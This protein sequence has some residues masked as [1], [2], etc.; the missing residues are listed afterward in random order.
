MYTYTYDGQ[1]MWRTFNLARNAVHQVL[2]D[3]RMEWLNSDDEA[4]MH[5]C[6]D[7]RQD[8]L[9]LVR[10]MDKYPLHPV[11]EAAIKLSRPQNWHL[12]FFEWPHVSE[13]DRARIAYTQS[14]D[15]GKRDLQTV[16]SVGKYLR[17]HFPAI[18]DHDI[19]D[20][21][22]RYGSADTYK[23]VSTTAE[24]IYHLHRG[25]GSCM[26]WGENRAVRCHD[27]VDRHPYEAYN[28]KYGWH[29]AVRICGDDTVGRALCM[30][31]PDGHK[32]FV[33]TYARPANGTNG[34]SQAD[35][36][37]ENWLSD[38]GYSKHSSWDDGEKLAYHGA[39]DHFLA[40][41]L[42]GGDKCVSVH[43]DEEEHWVMVDTDGDYI[44]DQTGGVPTYEDEDCFDCE[45]CGDSTSDDDGYWVGYNDDTHVCESCY[46]NEYVYGYGR[47]GRQYSFSSGD[48]VYVD[49]QQEYYHTSW[50]DANNI[51]EL[52][53]GEYEH[54]DDAVEVG[55]EW[56]HID[57]ENICRT[58][59]TDEFL[60][61]DDGCWQ[62]AESGDWYTDSVD[63]VE[64]DNTIYH[65]DNAPATDDE[66]V[67]EGDTA[68]AVA[69]VVTAPVVTAPVVNKQLT[70]EML[71][72]CAL[73]EEYDHLRQRMTYSLTIMH[74][75]LIFS[76]NRSY[77]DGFVQ[78]QGADWM[79]V[80]VRRILSN[81]LLGLPQSS[82]ETI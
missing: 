56:Y 29:M 75:G 69:P 59:D 10:E 68:V 64:I 14:I 73:V 58:T 28:P 31:K 26:V 18:S 80:N 38:Q 13:G 20:L 53:N 7:Y 71:N 40:P 55:G 67:S 17:R 51:V 30:T 23:F 78:S 60:L 19:R 47:N 21:V 27:G 8:R 32:Y 82:T 16:T 65:P 72:E 34:Y 46:E 2:H 44:C 79:R 81:E 76:T 6:S 62:C 41:Y 61:K 33:R 3:T 25:P 39:G 1:S 37:M 43:S 35:N 50:L 15:K 48:A 54:T 45:D 70:I 42:D 57:D 5:R 9:W 52:A 77:R 24:M 74:N 22:S 63:Y 66:D 11:I 12:M 4:V 49:S 36:G